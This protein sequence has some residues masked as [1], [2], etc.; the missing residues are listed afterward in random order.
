MTQK[1]LPTAAQLK[2]MAQINIHTVEK[3]SLVSAEGV[4]IHTE[5]SDRERLEDYIRQIGKLPERT[6]DT[7]ELSQTREEQQ[8][9]NEPP[10]PET[11]AGKE[12]KEDD[13]EISEEV[14]EAAKKRLG[15]V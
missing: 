6:D 14:V 12:P 11:A 13:E 10:E 2:E 5:L 1:R 4:Q 7:R 15:R 8:G 9:Q 3:E